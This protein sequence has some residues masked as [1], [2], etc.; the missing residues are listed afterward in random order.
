MMGF[1]S[2]QRVIVAL[3]FILGLLIGG[4]LF[5][6][7]GRKWKEFFAKT[8]HKPGDDLSQPIRWDQG[9]RYA[10]LNYRISRTLADSDTR[11][12]QARAASSGNARLRLPA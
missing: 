4:F 7:G 9:A 8:Y 2:D 3:V 11:Q 6:G 1:T 5:S 10:Q 12:S